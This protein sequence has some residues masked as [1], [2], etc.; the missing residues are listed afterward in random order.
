MYYWDS[1]EWKDI[2]YFFIVIKSREDNPVGMS[3]WHRGHVL[4]S[5]LYS[6]E[7]KDDSMGMYYYILIKGRWVG[8]L[9]WKA[10]DTTGMCYVVQLTREDDEVPVGVKE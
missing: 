9:G 6:D 1:D 2:Y 4:F 3:G 5:A 10:D 8:L 7:R